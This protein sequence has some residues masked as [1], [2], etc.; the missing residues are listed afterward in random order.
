MWFEDRPPPQWHP[1]TLPD[2]STLQVPELIVRG[3]EAGASGWQLRFGEWTFYADGRDGAAA[4]L[5]LAIAEM[6]ERIAYRG[7]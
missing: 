1:L 4:A 6:E 2:G 3:E 5:A 7:K